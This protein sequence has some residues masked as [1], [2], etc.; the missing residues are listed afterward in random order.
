MLDEYR[1]K[2]VVLAGGT[3]VVPELKAGR[4]KPE[5]VINIKTLAG[6]DEIR[7]DKDG[8]HIGAL[9]T[10]A[11]LA[12]IEIFKRQKATGPAEERVPML[13]RKMITLMA[14][15]QV[16]N[17]ATLSG[18]LAW[19][20]PAADSAPAL[21]ALDASVKVIGP[22][23][24]KKL[25]LDGFFLGPL[26]TALRQ[27][28]LITHVVIPTASLHKAGESKKFMKRKANTLAI[29]SAA[30]SVV[31]GTDKTVKDVRIAV[32]AVAPT[33]IRIKEAEDLLEGQV[34]DKDA[35]AKVKEK[36]ASEISP[37]TDVRSNAWFRRMITPVLVER[38]IIEAL[39]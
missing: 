23:G 8:L 36:V 12:H 38:C 24:E 28:E 7:E 17:I 31:N 4:L 10:L 11:E 33:P 27:N 20:S 32:G 37:I 18:N 25:P 22:E 14:N 6:L 35:I 13:L 19:G 15:P 34:V 30:V 39:A 1:D 3:N 29:S 2:A 9:V 16:R 26:K 21:L 5:Y